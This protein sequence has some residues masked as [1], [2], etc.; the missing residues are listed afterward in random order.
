MSVAQYTYVAEIS[1]QGARDTFS[2]K[3]LHCVT[4]FSIVSYASPDFDVIIERVS[5]VLVLHG[6]IFIE[7]GVH[8]RL[9]SMPLYDVA[10]RICEQG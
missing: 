3:S 5:S 6:P 9:P 4:F 10:H 2:E 7:A 8:F 1:F